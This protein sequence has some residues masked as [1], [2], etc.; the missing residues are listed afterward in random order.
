MSDTRSDLARRAE[1][2]RQAFDQ[3]FSLP[4]GSETAEAEDF[5]AIGVGPQA[6]AMRLSEVTGLFAGR[7]ITPLPGPSAVLRGIAGFRG[8]ILPVYDL[9]MLL[10][11]APIESARWLVI[12]A[13]A[14]VALAFDGFHGH[15]RISQES[16]IAQAEDGATAYARQYLRLEGIVRPV[17]HLPSIL[18]AIKAAATATVPVKEH[19]A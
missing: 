18:E 16:L 7:K 8:A 19:S 12:A 13:H 2:M 1:A 14:P 3:S 10:G 6:I 11:K 5:L 4:L 17:V 9:A 15:R